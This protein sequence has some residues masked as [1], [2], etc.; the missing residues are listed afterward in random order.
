MRLENCRLKSALL[1]LRSF[2]NNLQI[3][4]TRGETF[5]A[6]RLEDHIHEFIVAVHAG[7]KDDASPHAACLTRVPARNLASMVG[8]SPTTLTG[9]AR[10]PEGSDQFVEEARERRERPVRERPC[11]KSAG[12]SSR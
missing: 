10:G 7:V 2:S 1:S 11:N 12:R 4:Q 6:D 9:A 3:R 8:E 5:D